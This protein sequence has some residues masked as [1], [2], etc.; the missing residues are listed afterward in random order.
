MHKNTWMR[1]TS[2]LFVLILGAGGGVWVRNR[3]VEPAIGQHVEADLDKA[4]ACKQDATAFVDYPLVFAGDTALGYPLS[5]CQH[6]KTAAQYDDR[7][8]LFHAATDFFSFDYGSC[9]IAAGRE[10]CA[11]PVTII[12]DPPCGQLGVDASF[13]KETAAVRGIEALVD[14]E[15]TTWFNTPSYKI[16]VYPPG[17]TYVERKQNALAIITDLIPANVPAAGLLKTS[18]LTTTLGHS[19]VCP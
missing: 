18:P 3:L 2:L 15:G 13:A 7:G 17:N 6:N 11:V 19:S 14:E 10:S 8:Q 9:E 16:A 4:A 1:L 12:I 5:T